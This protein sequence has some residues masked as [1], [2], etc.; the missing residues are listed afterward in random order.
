E[1]QVIRSQVLCPCG[2]P[3]PQALLHLPDPFLDLSL[4]HQCPAT[5]ERT[6]CHPER[7]SLFRGEDTG[8]FRPLLSRPHLAAELMEQRGTAQSKGHAIGV[9][10]LLCQGYRLVTLHQSLIRIAQYPQCPRGIVVTHHP[11]VF[12]IEERMGA[13]LLGVV[14]SYALGTVRVRS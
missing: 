5:Q 2:T 6:H 8:G 13:I 4:A 3:S 9:R 14:K 10:T 11:R 12:P 1:R 7:K